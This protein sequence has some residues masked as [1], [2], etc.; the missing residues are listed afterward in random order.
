MD[1]LFCPPKDGGQNIL[2][3]HGEAKDYLSAQ[4]N[5]MKKTNAHKTFKQ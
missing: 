2:S 5:L 4:D 3:E 1:F